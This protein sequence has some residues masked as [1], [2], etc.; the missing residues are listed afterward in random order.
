[1]SSGLKSMKQEDIKALREQLLKANGYKCRCSGLPLNPE[2]AAL[3]HAHQSSDYTET[4]EGQVR[5]V[6]HKFVNSIEGQW[7]SKYLRSGLKDMITFEELLLAMYEYL[8][9]AREPYLHPS[10]NPKPR[11]LMK[12]SYN[13][14]K[15]EIEQV[16]KHL[17]KQIKIPPYPKSQRLTKR[18]KELF[19]QFDIEPK[20][21]KQTNKR[22]RK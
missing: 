19:E 6:I 17:H 13:Q 11:K 8:M 12:S 15:K 9:T 20:F 3:D 16:N 1:M 14:L 5:G 7:R 22:G 18:L 10:A 4:Q 2:D 21:Y